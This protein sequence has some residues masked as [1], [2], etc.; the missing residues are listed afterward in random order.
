MWLCLWIAL[1]VEDPVPAVPDFDTQ[2]MPILTKAGCNAGS[3]HGA[4]AGRGGFHLSLYGSRPATDFAEITL[5]LEGRRIDRIHSERSLLLLKPTEQL[6]HEGGTRLE[7][8]GCDHQTIQRWIASGAKRNESRR[9]QQFTLTAVPQETAANND[10]TLGQR[11]FQ[12]IANATFSDGTIDNVLPWTVLT[13]DDP[14]GVSV[15]STGVVTLLHPGRH[16]IMARFLD[17]VRPLELTVP[18]HI[19]RTTQPRSHPPASVDEFI[20]ARL[21]E[22]GLTAAPAAD[23]FAFIRRVTLDLTGRLP[24]PSAVQKFSGERGYDKR[25]LLIDRLLQSDEFVDFW[26]HRMAML[27]RVGQITGNPAAA[28]EYYLWLL[29]CV[30]HGFPLTKVARKVLLAEGSARNCGAAGFYYAASD[31][32][33]QAELVSQVFLGVRMQCA[34]CHD[35]PL[36]A[37]TQDDYHGLAA[38]FA[39]IRRGDVISISGTGDVIHPATGEPAI[40]KIPGGPFLVGDADHRAALATWMTS[41]ENPYFA[42]SFVNRVWSHLLGRGLVD[43]V[44]DFRVTNPATHSELLDWLAQDFV[45]HDYQLRHLIRRICTTQVYARGVTSGSHEPI[46]P[47]FYASAMAR[48]LSPEVFADAIADLSGP[49]STQRDDRRAISFDGI[50]DSSGSLELLGRCTDSCESP[51][52]QRANLAVQLELLNGA[53]FN[54]AL[55]ARNGF[56]KQTLALDQPFRKFINDCYLR[57]FS[58]PPR[59]EEIMFWQR[60][61]PE[62]TNSA[63]FSEVALDMFWSLLNSDEFCTNH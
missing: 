36:D 24:S 39:R 58:R 56:L 63:A 33:T 29:R 30:K 49:E 41:R 25:S 12:L 59:D 15:G 22:F 44:D 14:S 10:A 3:C 31:A 57:V 7:I 21:A 35:H 61:F 46:P 38:V 28:K 27:F 9:L 40:A 48:S 17:Q 45:D 13:P 6:S 1:L 11:Q 54:S 50:M 55:T 26:G 8:D 52:I 19:P 5:S 62:K 34:N 2:V 18:W 60:Q 43:P 47:E 23:D 16:L 51:V 53:G 32:R 37:W 4:A 20:E 42:K